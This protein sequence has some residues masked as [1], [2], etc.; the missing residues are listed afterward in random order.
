[1]PRHNLG[2]ADRC[3]RR[4]QTSDA[5]QSQLGSDESSLKNNGKKHWI[6]CMTAPL[7]TVF[8]IAATRSR[9]VLEELITEDYDGIVNFDYFSANCS[10]A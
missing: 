1:V 2:F 6:W 3:S 9:S 8:H 4:T 10:F 7:F 5:P